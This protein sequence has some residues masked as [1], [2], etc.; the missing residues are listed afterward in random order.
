MRIDKK[1][2]TFLTFLIIV[3]IFYFI[4]KSFHLNW[5]EILNLTFKLD[6]GKLFLGILVYLFFLIFMSYC[7]VI[8]LRN[9]G[10]KSNTIGLMSIWL[11]S[12]P[13]KYVPGK[14]GVIAGRVYLCKRQGLS[15]SKVFVSVFLEN[16]LFCVAGMMLFAISF[17]YKLNFL[18]AKHLFFLL[19][20]F[21]LFL[22]FL[23]PYLLRYTNTR[24]LKVFFR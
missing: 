15:G 21:I 19:G 1:A 20:I 22:F 3:I 7:W 24:F 10:V 12:R 17:G 4:W 8:G 16:A 14:V 2:Q 6:Y 13:A 9:L 11:L 18:P 5:H 23:H